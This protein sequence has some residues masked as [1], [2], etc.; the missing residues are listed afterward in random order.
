ML[1]YAAS[2]SIEVKVE[3]KMRVLNLNELNVVSGGTDLA[4]LSNT[5]LFT[6]GFFAAA[7]ATMGGIAA[8]PLTAVMAVAAV[9]YYGIYTP[10]YYVAYGSYTVGAFVGNSIYNAG[11]YV[12]DSV[13]G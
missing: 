11:A 7:G 13:V 2:M 3:V 5:E 1:R 8:I 6:K 10:I 9:G 4:D 12:Y